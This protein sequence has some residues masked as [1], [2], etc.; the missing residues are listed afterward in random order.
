MGNKEKDEFSLI[1]DEYITKIYRFIFLKVSTPEIAEDLSSEVFTR[2]WKEFNRKEIENIQAFLYG[3]ARNLIADHYR[4][5]E[6]GTIV[7]IEGSFDIQ[8]EDE[9]LQDRAKVD[10]DMEMV[11][12][13]LSDINEEYQNYIIWRYLEELSIT[14]IAEIIDKSEE[15]VRVGVHRALQSLKGKLPIEGE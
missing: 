3:V 15:S 4:V 8:D 14:E 11:R 10:S 1:Y 7:S 6:K 9:N 5:K 12:N 13:A 2:T